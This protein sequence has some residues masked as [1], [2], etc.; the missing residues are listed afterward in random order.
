M[1][2]PRLMALAAA[3]T[4]MQAA[5]PPPPS[6]QPQPPPRFR[7]ATNLVR[8]DVYATKGG[9]AVQDLKA[10]DFEISE[11]DAAQKIDSF[12]HIVVRGGSPEGERIE[13][14]TVVAANELAA[15]PRRRVFVL[16]LD[17]EHVNA[18]GSH[19]IMEP[20]IDLI[21]RIMGPDDLVAIMTPRMTPS[22]M[23]FG[24]RTKVIEEGLRNNWTWG[25]RDTIVL[26]DRERMYAECFQPLH[27][28][29]ESPSELAWELIRRR[30]E[31]MAL[32]S[33]QG[34][35]RHMGAMREGRTAVIAVTPGWVM[36]GRNVGLLGQRNN[37]N[38][39]I[40]D[41]IPGTPPPVVVGPRGALTTKDPNRSDHDTTE[42][43]RDRMDL[44][45]V[46]HAKEFR[47]L[48]GEANRANVSFYPIDPRGLAAVDA[49]IGPEKPP[50]P[51]QDRA[52]A[53]A[54]Q[55][56]LRIIADNTDGVALLINND[57]KTSLRRVAD[58]LTSYY[59]LGYYSTNGTLDGKFR[60]IKVRSKR[61]G[62]TVRSRRG[63]NAA[64][65]DEVAKARAAAEAVI[66]D[67]KAALARAIG[68][69]ETDARAASRKTTRA[70][71]EPAVFHRGP[72]TGNQVQPAAG[73]IFP[74]SERI[75][76]EIEAAAGAPMWT[77]VVLDRNGAKTVV[78]VATSE[79]TDPAT[80][81]RWLVADVTLGP[82]G[83]GDYAVE[84]ST[85][86]GSETQ[87][88]LV[89]FRVTQ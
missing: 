34:L 22:Q 46:D 16:Y 43:V 89:A 37:M 23:T 70:A 58:D 15:D 32:E 74:R 6:Q 84:L 20:L 78:P 54:R 25:R 47:D 69:L 5:P 49:S 10:D 67:A 85:V 38:N 13:P 66:P 77:G 9:V 4:L 62:V 36:Y 11:D 24:R 40:A 76:L 7:A 61:P 56:S 12:E 51:I 21:S 63:Y 64:T 44:A 55:D 39:S 2:F 83:P 86:K 8:V 42:C 29:N 14:G 65:A 30:R 75:R 28:G 53:A 80:G 87:K 72:S 41:P 48:F 27:D 81:Q 82:L 73:R 1:P 45:M 79:R 33:L 26:D 35:I 18:D 57:L 60:S 59:L 52:N 3:L 17:V 68:A 88:A 50:S 19:A 71:G 31:R